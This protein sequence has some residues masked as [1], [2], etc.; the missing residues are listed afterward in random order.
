M[1]RIGYVALFFVSAA[2][3]GLL[4]TFGQNVLSR[5][6]VFDECDDSL[7]PS[8]C[9][10]NQLVYR[11][12]FSLGCFFSLTALLS[13][14]VAK[15]CENVC[16]IL[17]FQLPFYLG[18]LL[19]SLFIP[20]DFFDGYVDIARVSSA[21]FII[22]Q[23]I[24]ILDLTYSLR[25]YILDKM[26]EADRDDDARHALLGSS[27]DSTQGDGR[28]TMWEGAYLA[29]V[30]I[31]T[32]LSIVG[33]ALMYMR[34]A[35]CELNVIFISITLL[36]VVILTAL[37]VVAW[38]NVG[39][40]PS[41]AVSLYLVFLCYQ[42]VRANPSASC[43]SLHVS[44]E[45]KMQEQS[46]VIM[47]SFV[48]AFT[49][50][51]TSWRTSATST[52]FFSSSSTKKQSEDDEEL[53][54]IGLTSAR[55][56]KE[57]Q[58]EVEVVPEYQF[59]V[60]MVL[61]SLY[62][63]MVLTNWGSFDGSSSNDD[64]IV[65]M[66]VKAI[67]QWVASGLFLWTLVAPA[68]FPNR[69]FLYFKNGAE[70]VIP[71]TA[72][73]RL[74]CANTSVEKSTA[75]ARR[76]RKRETA[77][78]RRAERLEELTAQGKFVPLSDRVRNALQH[79]YDRF[80]GARFVLRDFLP[81]FQEGTGALPDVLNSL[82]EM[83][84]TEV[85][86]DGNVHHNRTDYLQVATVSGAQVV[87][88][89]G[90]SFAQ[91]DVRTLHQLALGRHKL[92]LMDPPWQNKS[93][94]RGK[95]YDMLDH[96]ELLKIH[97]PHIADPDECILA[98]WVTNRPRYMAY[99]REQA[100]PSWGF[101]YHTCWYWLKLSKNGEL[102]TPLDSTHRLPVETLAVAYRAKD[103]A[104]EQT[105]RQRLGEQMRIVLSIPLRHSW[106]PP[107]ECFFDKDIMSTTHRKVELFAREL[108]PHWTSVG[109]EVLKFQATDLFQ[110][111]LPD[112]FYMFTQRQV[113]AQQHLCCC[114]LPEEK[115]PH[116][117]SVSAQVCV[118][119]IRLLLLT[120]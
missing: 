29:L 108:R 15:G 87:L 79:A 61:A 69:D 37:S 120:G 38:V 84:S 17:L 112:S 34:Y 105:L 96:S 8:N 19:A 103:Q 1:A 2:S 46:G 70:G 104:H 106:K 101:T 92:I 56:D 62:M 91:R 71:L 58:R 75:A 41:T 50:T 113:P 57:G 80:G 54:S 65:T 4:C 3:A 9:V 31:C 94:S 100:L 24:I 44:T 32:A 97:V 98:V 42:T 85:L 66:W 114:L 13:C 110:S 55:L 118:P 111:T 77:A 119:K 74:A 95:R 47:N 117:Q 23:I 115:D 68:V 16:C 59:H 5:L 88:P 25:D 90:S 107:L 43:A 67:S 22:L 40:L 27:F 10:G 26:D 30:F 51:W 7:Y 81:S 78:R 73:I 14:A 116:A 39:L 60:L 48:A 35:E 109:N 86:D 21:L 93:V 45:K 18:I 36:S 102:V 12:S 99:L 82:Q 6:G 49:V 64:E 28:K 63:A 72:F 53:A 89:A 76:Q 83:P 20:N 11:I 52:V 33:L